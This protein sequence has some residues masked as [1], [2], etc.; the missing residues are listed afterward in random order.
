MLPMMNQRLPLPPHHGLGLLNSFMHHASP[1]DLMTSAAH[2]HH[3]EHPPTRT[4]NTQPSFVPSDPTENECKIVEYRGQKVAA[5]IIGGETMLCLPQAFD[6]FLK[7]L[8]GGLHTVHSKLKRLDIV[9][10]VC[11]V[12]QI[13]LLRGLGALQPGVNRCKLLSSKHFD[14][15]YRDCTQA[16]C[17]SV[18][19]NENNRR[20]R[21]PKQGLPFDDYNDDEPDHGKKYRLDEKD[22]SGNEG[23]SQDDGNGKSKYSGISG[24]YNPSA[25]HLNH[26]QF[27]QMN[28]HRLAQSNAIMGQELQAQAHLQRAIEE[29]NNKNSNLANL[30]RP[31][32]WET[33]SA[34]YESFVKNL[35]RLRKEK[36]EE[37]L[38]NEKRRH[39][40]NGTPN[41]SSILNLS[42]NR[43]RSQSPEYI[44]NTTD[45]PGLESAENLD[46]NE[47]PSEDME[48]SENS[49]RSRSQTPTQ[50]GSIGGKINYHAR[51]FS[52][53]APT[54]AFPSTE[55]LLRNIQELLKVVLENSIQQ[56]QQLSFEKAELKMNALREREIN[57]NLERR[58]SEEQKLRVL[59]QKRYNRDRKYRFKLQKQI[60]EEYEKHNR[61]EE[62]LKKSST[63]DTLKKLTD[64]LRENKKMFNN[65]TIVKSTK[66][67]TE[68]I[69]DEEMKD[70]DASDDTKEK[71][72]SSPNSK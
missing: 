9:P 10:L 6:L 24:D 56:E 66:E 29:N 54:I 31:N 40:E 13:R 37:N 60:E 35:E 38:E 48:V 69:D 21:P 3:H 68:K 11:T 55:I 59:Y 18:K 26:I 33:C 17:M 57:S 72:M 4:Y 45:S 39:S 43:E 14:I 42:K 71:E 41:E 61:L 62:I 16:R 30:H 67:E 8:V 50:L 51:D 58:L 12:E 44:R 64:F 63:T 47:D 52:R 15:L 5:F 20:G 32:L 27:M 34:S 23:H 1:L 53:P 46:V 19:P 65:N 7:N 49:P 25:M 22:S 2:H 70:V 36:L 28:Q